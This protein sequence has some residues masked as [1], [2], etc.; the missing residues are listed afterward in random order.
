MIWR[1]EVEL[2]PQSRKSYAEKP[3][4]FVSFQR[5]PLLVKLTPRES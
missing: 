1:F 3:I 4:A 2:D 5:P